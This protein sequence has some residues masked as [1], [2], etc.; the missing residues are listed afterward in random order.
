[1]QTYGHERVLERSARTRVCVHV[2]CR[3]AWHSQ[4]LPES[5]EPAVASAIVA[6]ERSLQFDSQ[7]VAPERVEQSPERELVVHSAARAA[8]EADQPLGVIEHVAQRH[9]GLGRRSGFLTGVRVGPGQDPAE[10]GPPASILDQQGQMA[11]IVEINLRPMNR[12]QP[13]CLCGDRE[14]HRAR[15]GVVVGQGE[16]FVAQLQRGWNKLIRERRAIEERKRGM[17]VEFDV[18]HEH[19]FVPGSD[20]TLGIRPPVPQ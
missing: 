3:Y 15:D 5:S 16:C 6:Q 10:V 20:R 7:P 9:V 8:A 18:G 12:T 2:A 1:M 13:E 17:A 4:P 11:A 14:L 19:M